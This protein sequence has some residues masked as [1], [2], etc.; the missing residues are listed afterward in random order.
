MRLFR[1]TRI[2]VPKI[3]RDRVFNIAHESH[4]AV[5]ETKTRLPFKMWWLKMAM[6]FLV[7]CFVPLL[8][9]IL[10]SCC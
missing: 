2:V 9:K 1:G 8:D 5:G 10:T 7:F 3:Q 4:Q 6:M